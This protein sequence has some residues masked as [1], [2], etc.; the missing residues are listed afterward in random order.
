MLISSKVDQPLHPE[1]RRT[2]HF[3]VVEPV[4]AVRYPDFLTERKVQVS[5][6]S[7]IVTV[8]PQLSLRLIL[9]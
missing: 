2:A 6:R 3:Q 5:T 7:E 4:E 1:S 8:V 9:K